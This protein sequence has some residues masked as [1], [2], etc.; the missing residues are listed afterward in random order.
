MSFARKP[1]ITTSAALIAL[2]ASALAQ[3]AA[4]Q[5]PH[6]PI[7]IIVPFAPGGSTDIL[8]RVLHQFDVLPAHVRAEPAGTKILHAVAALR[9][10]GRFEREERG[11]MGLA[12]ITRPITGLAYR[13][14]K[15]RFA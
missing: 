1:S 10:P 5:S 12:D 11:E 14:G 15:S 9:R 4:D 7:K 3:S 8:A 6:K 2:G 13:A